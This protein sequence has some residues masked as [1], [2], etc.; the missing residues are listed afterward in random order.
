MK[1]NLE[2]ITDWMLT[3][4]LTALLVGVSMFPS[5]AEAQKGNNAVYMNASNCCAA[6]PAFIDAGVFA[7]NFASP[8]LCSV[9][10]FVLTPINGI[11]PSTGAVIDARGLPGSRPPTSMTCTGTNPSPWA[12]IT[13]PPPSTILLPATTAAAPIVI[14]S[15]WILPNN[16]RLIGEGN[17]ITSSGSTPGTTL[18]VSG[19]FTAPGPM[20][21]FGS[22]SGCCTG[23][24]V[25]HLTLDGTGG[26]INGIVNQNAGDLSYVDQVGLYRILGTGLTISGTANHS[27][28]Y[29]NIIYDLGGYS[30]NSGT[31]CASINGLSDTRGIHGL[32]CIS[33]TQRES[34]FFDEY[35]APEYVHWELR[36]RHHPGG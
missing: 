35:S 2:S 34:V 25:E 20:I 30:G 14:P 18:Q 6:T 7:G 36:P 19:T 28:P 1:Y 9:L 31:V 12:G 15:T 32:T 17:T 5:R 3:G 10:N 27:G 16:T 26:F 22:S 33:E 4:V 24:S 21:Q 13:N 29:S 11:I 8:N 23:I